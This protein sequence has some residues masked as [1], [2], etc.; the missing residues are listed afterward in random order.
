M[1][2][3][4][5]MIEVLTYVEQM[6]WEDNQTIPT[7]EKIAEVTGVGLQTIKN[8]WKNTDF[9]AAL[10]HRGV[11]F[12]NDPDTGKALTYEQLTV[13]NML[14]NVQDRRSLREKLAAA[15]GLNVTPS[16]VGTWMRQPA[17]QAH[18]RKRSDDLFA[19]ADTSAN[20]ALVKAIDAGD[21][22]AVTLFFEM[23]GRYTP[24]TQVDVNI[25][26]IL[27]RVVEIISIHVSDPAT[28]EAIAGELEGLVPGQTQGAL[29]AGSTPIPM[30][31]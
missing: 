9:R 20:M 12:A 28:L 26:S 6:W 7:N 27:A 22:K 1:S 4:M 19:G 5:E 13:A 2:L 23:T 30:N 10:S 16:Q 25:H 14:M 8:Y 3:S 31:V 17:F 15:E 11:Q 29:P 24:R 18:L 21:L